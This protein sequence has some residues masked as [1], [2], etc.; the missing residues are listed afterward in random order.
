MYR[1]WDRFFRLG[2]WS[3]FVMRDENGG[4]TYW[5]VNLKRYK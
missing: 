5:T 1:T 4:G 3:L 2:R